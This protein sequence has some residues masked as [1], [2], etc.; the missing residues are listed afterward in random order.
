D[1]APRVR[2]LV[3]R[4]DLT[5]QEIAAALRPGL[6]EAP[7]DDKHQRFVDA[8]LFGQG[9][10]ASRNTLVPAVVDG[11]LTRAGTDYG[12]VPLDA[13]ARTDPK[14]RRAAEEALSIHAYVDRKVANAGRPSPDGHDLAAGIRDDALKAAALLYKDHLAAHE[15]G[16]RTP[17]RVSPEMLRL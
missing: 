16:L 11:L 4:P 9:S 7:F 5:P 3:G 17:G 8:L 14:A 10:A 1:T 15:A 6:S 12:D 13:S 2:A